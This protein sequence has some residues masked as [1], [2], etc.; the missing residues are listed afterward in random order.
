[1]YL[2]LHRHAGQR[3]EV[4]RVLANWRNGWI[5]IRIIGG[6]VGQE[7]RGS[8]IET[9]ATLKPDVTEEDHVLQVASGYQLIGVEEC[10]RVCNRSV[11]SSERS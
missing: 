6:L 1:L 5:P 4:A 3:V 2:V 10:L 9:K 8:A 11:A 7:V